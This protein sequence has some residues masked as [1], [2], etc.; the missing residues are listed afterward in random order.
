MKSTDGKYNV[1]D[2]V[3]IGPSP[4]EGHYGDMGL[5]Y[6]PE[7]DNNVGK[8]GVITN[9]NTF[10]NAWGVRII[11]TEETWIY[12]EEWFVS[13]VEVGYQYE[14]DFMSNSKEA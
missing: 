5:Y 13:N 7:M 2:T 4:G 1:G 9:Y 10:N 14:F 6:N 12:L 3:K 8:E 11:S